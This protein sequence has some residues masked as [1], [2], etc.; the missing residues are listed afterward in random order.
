MERRNKLIYEN[1]NKNDQK[2]QIEIDFNYDY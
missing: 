1:L 2:N